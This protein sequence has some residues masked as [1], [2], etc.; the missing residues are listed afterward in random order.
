M[1]PRML[2]TDAEAKFPPERI[3]MSFF[4]GPRTRHLTEIKRKLR[5]SLYPHAQLD[6]LLAIAQARN[7]SKDEI[8]YRCLE[9]ATEP[10]I[11]GTALTCHSAIRPVHARL[12]RHAEWA[13]WA[14]TSYNLSRE[15]TSTLLK[16]S[17]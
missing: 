9:P 6:T 5:T 14:C 17:I 10:E 4:I 1:A 13:C 8:A 12:A 2:V 15:S 16:T 3:I 7:K 11:A